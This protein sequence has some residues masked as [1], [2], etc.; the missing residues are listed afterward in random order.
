MNVQQSPSDI[1]REAAR[2][3]RGMASE[4]MTIANATLAM[5]GDGDPD[6][7]RS[8]IHAAQA[9]ADAEFPNDFISRDY[10]I[11]AAYAEARV[12]RENEILGSEV[13]K[14]A[15]TALICSEGAAENAN[16]T[17]EWATNAY[18]ASSR[19]DV[20]GAENAAKA[21]LECMQATQI[22]LESAWQFHE[23]VKKIKRPSLWQRLRRVF[24]T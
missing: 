3:A 4:T 13:L 10:E 5:A 2:I 16:E 11:M 1:S 21:A 8:T 12:E 9:T 22:A 23:T 15:R 24:R 19:G 17:E 18:E 14:F 7:A 6:F 20:I